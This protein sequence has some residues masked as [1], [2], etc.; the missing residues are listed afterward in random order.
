M[1]VLLD[2]CFPE[3]YARSFLATKSRLLLKPGKPA[4]KTAR[5]CNLRQRGLKF[6]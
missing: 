1:R 3:P 5:F 4:S 6:S 2:E